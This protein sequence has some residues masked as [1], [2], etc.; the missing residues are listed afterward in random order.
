[1]GFCLSFVLRILRRNRHSK[2]KTTIFVA[3]V[4]KFR[5]AR[6]MTDVGVSAVKLIQPLIVT[7]R[8]RSSATPRVC[9][10]TTRTNI[11][12]RAFRCSAPAVWNS[13]TADI[14]DSCSLP[15]PLSPIFGPFLL[16]PNIGRI[17]I[18]LGMEVGLSPGDF[19]LDGDPAPS[20]ERG[21]SPQFP[22]NV[23]CG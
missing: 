2:V 5:A 4:R 1:M 6:R 7:R 9:K 11:A 22:A 3:H 20:S 16:W 21:R 13:L 23:C 12:D 14:V 19:V 15:A 8:L 18:P 10:P 17:K